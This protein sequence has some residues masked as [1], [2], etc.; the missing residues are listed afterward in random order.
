MQESPRTARR[1]ASCG[2][3]RVMRLRHRVRYQAPDGRLLR[4][5]A[6]PG[7]S[8][9]FPPSARH[10][11]TGSAKCG[12]GWES[13]R[14]HVRQVRNG[15]WVPQVHVGPQ[16]GGARGARALVSGGVCSPDAPVQSLLLRAPVR[17]R[18]RFGPGARGHLG[19][20]RAPVG[21]CRRCGGHRVAFPSEVAGVWEVGGRQPRAET[22]ESEVVPPLSEGVP[23]LLQAG[24]DAAP[25]V[26]AERLPLDLPPRIVR[27]YPVA[28]EGG[29]E[30]LPRWAG[31]P[32]GK[33]CHIHVAPGAVGRQHIPRA[34]VRG[35]LV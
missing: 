20:L 29:G 7:V 13:G 18:G 11:A 35:V 4:L 5:V 26:P 19:A 34:L 10:G 12:G 15:C 16:E 22:A 17:A 27:E 1:V 6:G 24:A 2:S 25:V 33:V 9:P 8:R 14:K 28:V 32:P 3:V 31:V 23:D 21:A 30:V